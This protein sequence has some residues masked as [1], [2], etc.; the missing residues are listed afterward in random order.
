MHLRLSN[1]DLSVA[2]VEKPT[3]KK[4]D[5]RISYNW[6]DAE[7]KTISEVV[8]ANQPLFRCEHCRSNISNVAPKL[9]ETIENRK[10]PSY[11]IPPYQ[12]ISKLSPLTPLNKRRLV[13]GLEKIKDQVNDSPVFTSCLTSLSKGLQKRSFKSMKTKGC[14][15]ARSSSNGS[16]I[17]I[18]SKSLTVLT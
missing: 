5:K 16:V 9:F 18:A 13:L 10:V 4:D 15:Q 6:N 1:D 3:G 14:H 11:T 2:V 12:Q 8:V 17:Q 7:I